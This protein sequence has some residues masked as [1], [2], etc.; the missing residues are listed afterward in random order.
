M[1]L[2]KYQ[3]AAKALV[4]SKPMATWQNMAEVLYDPFV[5][6]LQAYQ[7]PPFSASAVTIYAIVLSHS[8]DIKNKALADSLNC[9]WLG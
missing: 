6:W 7:V 5:T 3:E 9:R 8:C 1:G 2:L 4:A